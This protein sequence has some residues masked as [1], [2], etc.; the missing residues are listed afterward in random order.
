VNVTADL[1]P[2]AADLRDRLPDSTTEGA[3]FAKLSTYRV[4]GPVA[5]LV[6]VPHVDALATVADA[7]RR[8]QPRL[9]VIGRGSNLLMSDAG[10]SGLVVVLEGDFETIDVA[11]QSPTALRAGGAVPLPV[12]ARRAATA[13]IAGLEFYVGIP[14]SVGGAVR[15][16]AGGHGRETVEVLRRAWVLDLLDVNAP[17][18][19]SERDVADLELGYRHSNLRPSEV[20]AAA[21]FT[22]TP[23]EPAA[24]EARVAE[25]VRW[26]REHQPGG[27]NAGSVFRNPPGDSAGRLIDAAGL[28]GLRVGGAVV[29]DKHA[30]FIQANAGATAR[31]VLDLVAEVQRRVKEA[32]GADLVPELH[33]VG[34]D[35]RDQGAE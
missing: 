8:H 15:M 22:V 11:A 3:S 32:S 16:N 14:G 6:R 25:I 33:V 17:P 27:Q 28:K 5:V 29:S 34:D 18:T 30:N 23:D 10:F 20:V 24:C 1:A 7:A 35:T 19:P 4:G 26:R 2:L 13:G 31:D 21:E 9:L 12:L